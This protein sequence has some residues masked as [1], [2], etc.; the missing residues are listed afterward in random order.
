[1]LFL[2]PNE[3]CKHLPKIT[4]VNH[5]MILPE[6]EVSEK[7]EVQETVKLES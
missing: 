4:E 6:A 7:S 3:I 2:D 1:M 5:I